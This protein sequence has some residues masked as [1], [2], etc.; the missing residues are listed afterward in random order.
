MRLN[1][2][3][4][5]H[6][7]FTVKKTI[8]FIILIVY[9]IL[10]LSGCNELD[11]TSSI[12]LSSNVSQADKSASKTIRLLYSSK[13]SLDPYTCVTEQNA[14]L[15]QLI[16]DP[17][18]ILNNQ[19]EIEYR[20]AESVIVKDNLCTIKLINA[21][22]SD[23]SSVTADDVIFSFNKAKNSKTTRHSSALKYATSAT[24]NDSLTVEISLKRNDPYFANLLTFP[25]MKKGSDELKDTDNQA[26]AP[27]GAGRYVFNNQT[28]TLSLNPNYYGAI[29]VIKNIETVD[30]PDTESVTQAINAGMVDLYFSDLSGNTIPKMNGTS[31][32]ISQ[33]RIVFLGINAKNPQ[34]SNSL[35]RQAIS[36]AI[37]RQE[38]CKTA[39]YGN[40]T[41]ALGPVPT[42]WQPVDGMLSI[43]SNSNVEIAQNNIELAGYTKKDEEGYFLLKNNSPITF[44]LL[45][46]SNNNSRVSAANIISKALTD[47]GI[48]LKI[49]TVSDAQYYAMLRSGNYDLYLGEI[50]YEDNMDISGL[51]DLNS[52]SKLLPNANS[53]NNTENTSSK[54]SSKSSVS[55]SS[56]SPNNSTLSSA[57]E[58]IIPGEITL[59]TVDAYKGFYNGDY[60]LQ[61]LIT[62]FNAEL[63]VIPICFKNGMVI[64][65]DRFGNG[66]TPSRTELF[67]GIQ[68][69]K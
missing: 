48:K 10:L 6:G 33:N 46:N 51:I 15:S 38:I 9:T 16:F 12:T 4:F 35:F 61:D 19:Y 18:L 21:K 57:E 30:C 42:I 28:A 65:S 7:R 64:Y 55:N 36:S 50:R 25:I 56:K 40:A 31:L 34:L 49:N 60:T 47:I 43:Q 54:T 69:L 37:N 22:F 5:S 66:I 39:Y 41:P 45:V 3:I 2:S 24:A 44:T 68:Y 26:L 58:I 13:D 1:I 63:P 67:H 32:G 23:G 62:A 27:I 14:D 17:L 11:N 8:T 52:A 29:S 20:L 53:S 59:T